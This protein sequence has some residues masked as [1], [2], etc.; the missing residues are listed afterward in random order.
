[1]CVCDMR[2]IWLMVSEI[3]SEK[4]GR[5]DTRQDMVMTISRPLLY[6][7]GIKKTFLQPCFFCLFF[8]SPSLTFFRQLT[9][10]SGNLL[11][12]FFLN[13]LFP[14]LKLYALF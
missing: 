9:N 14:A 6:G 7:Q 5:T 2:T 8:S 4:H 10:F 1:M 12:F 3:S 13:V 11:N